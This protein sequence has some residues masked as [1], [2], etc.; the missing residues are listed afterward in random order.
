MEIWLAGDVHVT[1]VSATLFFNIY[2]NMFCLPGTT[3]EQTAVMVGEAQ[4]EKGCGYYPLKH[5]SYG[6][7][8]GNKK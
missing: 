6:R 3:M 1:T 4:D 5:L 8:I 2:V 7:S